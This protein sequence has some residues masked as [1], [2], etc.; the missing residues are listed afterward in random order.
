M[1]KKRE[2]HCWQ[3]YQDTLN[4]NSQE[5]YDSIALGCSKTCL[6]LKGHE[7]EHKWTSDDEIII[8]FKGQ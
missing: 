8:T 1:K 3:D 7:G 4:M 5:Y 2:V 6:L